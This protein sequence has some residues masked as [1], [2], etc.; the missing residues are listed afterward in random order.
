MPVPTIKK[1]ELKLQNRLTQIINQ[2]KAAPDWVYGRMTAADYMSTIEQDDGVRETIYEQ[3]RAQGLPPITRLTQEQQTAVAKTVNSQARLLSRHIVRPTPA[4]SAQNS[5]LN[6]DDPSNPLNLQLNPSNSL[7]YN[8]YLATMA[9]Q[10]LQHIEVVKEIIQHANTVSDQIVKI[11]DNDISEER[12]TEQA[13]K[14]M[15]T[16]EQNAQNIQQQINN[17]Q[18]SNDDKKDDTETE[19]EKTAE[20]ASTEADD[21]AATA[22][23]DAT[24]D[25][26]VALKIIKDQMHYDEF[27][28]IFRGHFKSDAEEAEQFLGSLPRLV[29]NVS[30]R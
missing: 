2:A 22:N 12:Q 25:T 27:R 13:Q 1:L 14:I 19:A 21:D 28:L 17:L 20:Q 26:Q 16:N 30:I 7:L 3:L 9:V 6:P 18:Q 15:E 10:N 4:P 24:N 29:P 23:A 5:H 8:N 11:Q